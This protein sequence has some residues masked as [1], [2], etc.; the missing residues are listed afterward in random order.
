MGTQWEPPKKMKNLSPTP[1][2]PKRKKFGP[3]LNF[4]FSK[5]ATTIITKG[6]RVIISKI[7]FFFNK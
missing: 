7:F 6:R 2:Q 4:Y 1:P 3:Q 5:R